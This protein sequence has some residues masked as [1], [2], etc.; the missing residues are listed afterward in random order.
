MLAVGW[1]SLAGLIACVQS[2]W[3]GTWFTRDCLQ[4]MHALTAF[5]VITVWYLAV[6][7][8]QLDV[9]LLQPQRAR[10]VL[11]YWLFASV[12]LPPEVHCWLSTVLRC[13]TQPNR[14]S[15]QLL[16]RPATQAL[17]DMRSFTA[18]VRSSA[19]AMVW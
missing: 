2:G 17:C 10:V 14:D 1:I 12:R 6:A 8:W 11:Q 3:L 4:N 15:L 5:D 18:T 13:Q 7:A 16:C 9:L 19:Y